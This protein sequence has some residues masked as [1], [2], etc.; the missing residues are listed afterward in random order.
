[1]TARWL[2]LSSHNTPSAAALGAWRTDPG[3]AACVCRLS[4]GLLL[5]T[6]Y[7][8][9]RAA[10]R[11]AGYLTGA[12]H[13]LHEGAAMSAQCRK[14]IAHLPP[15]DELPPWADVERRNLTPAMIAE[16][17]DCWEQE[18]GGREI[19]FYTGRVIESLVPAHLR[20]RYARYPLVMAAYPNDTPEGIPPPMDAASVARRNAPPPASYQLYIPAPWTS[21]RVHQ[22]TGQGRLP[23]YAGNVDLSVG[24]LP[25]AVVVTDALPWTKMGPHHQL[26]GGD[27]VRWVRKARP[28]VAKCVGDFGPSFEAHPAG[29]LWLGRE[30]DDGWLDGQGFD[31]NRYHTE[32]A[33]AA[34]IARKYA[35]WLERSITLNPHVHVWEGPNEQVVTAPGPM[36]WYAAF[37]HE[38]ARQMRQRGKRAGLGAW[39]TGNPI[40]EHNLWPHYTRALDAV[41]EF[42]AVLTRHEYGPL[43]EFNGLR[44]R[45]D[46]RVF[47]GLGYPDLPVIISECGTDDVGGGWLPWR[48]MY[49]GDAERYWREWVLPYT[50]EI[51]RDAYCLGA[52]LFSVGLWDRFD[53]DGTII[54]DRVIAQAHSLRAPE[55]EPIVIHVNIIDNV[56]DEHRRAYI[57]HIADLTAHVN[58]GNAPWPYGPPGGAPWWDQP[59]PFKFR[60]QPVAALRLYRADRVTVDRTVSY[61]GWEIDV[62]ETTPDGWLRISASGLWLRAAD[63]TP[64]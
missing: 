20:A 16:W 59:T 36:A 52:T 33:D 58:A 61:T 5:D 9:H 23:G 22:Y 35:A 54:P 41:R 47:T 15:D 7:L 25:A 1:M 19:W 34:D 38:F 49:A 21:A 48:A 8:R 50:L 64:L 13:A 46:N 24:A 12:Y 43:D 62:F 10:A 29:V 37:L 45:Y 56:P 2:D 32:G 39:S 18:T 17:F 40:R 30:V 6:W 51:E 42:D 31:V 27:T 57:E 3:L 55:K 4:V 63:V 60:A 26:G 44:Y 11:S 14:F 53:V 28:R